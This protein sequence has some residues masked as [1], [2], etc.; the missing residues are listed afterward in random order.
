MVVAVRRSFLGDRAVIC[1]EMYT[2]IIATPALRASIDTCASV[3]AVAVELETGIGIVAVMVAEII[4]P[5][6]V[7]LCCS[8]PREG[9]GGG[10][11]GRG[12]GRE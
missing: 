9:G 2:N 11:G 12:G 5:V 1:S 4:T 6:V 3:G 8:P 7:C 10:R